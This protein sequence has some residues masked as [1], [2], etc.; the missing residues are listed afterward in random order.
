MKIG[1]NMEYKRGKKDEIWIRKKGGD[2]WVCV[3]IEGEWLKDE[4]LKRMENMKSLD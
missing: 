1:V 4:L 3:K 2:E